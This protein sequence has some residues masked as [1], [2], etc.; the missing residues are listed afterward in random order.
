MDLTTYP[1]NFRDTD[2]Q[3]L[4]TF[5]SK[6]LCRN[7]S[8]NMMN[9]VLSRVLEFSIN[10]KYQFCIASFFTKP[11]VQK[12]EIWRRRE[13]RREK[14][15]KNGGKGRDGSC[16]GFDNVF[17]ITAGDNFAYETQSIVTRTQITFQ[18]WHPKKE[19]KLH[20]QYWDSHALSRLMVVLP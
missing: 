2:V 4:T 11:T 7:S 6:F 17:L 10:L 8:P 15:E 14:D 13:G 16:L 3:M 5:S 20:H 12:K 19:H 1:Q 18:P 9:L